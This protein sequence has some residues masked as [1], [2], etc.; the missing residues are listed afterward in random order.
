ML[1]LAALVAGCGSTYTGRDFIARADAICASATRRLRS[2][3]PP[4]LSQSQAP[5]SG[6]L[7]AYLAMVVSVVQSQSSQL[8]ALPRPAQ[9]AGGRAALARWRAAV[10]QVADDYRQLE[11]AG[12]RGDAQGA[13]SAEAALRA[14]PAGSLAA[15]DGLTSCAA[16][17]ATIT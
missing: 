7:A 11:A 5:Q 13:A 9:N 2:I 6:A 8:H 17:G 12:R 4:S 1:A 3:P 10:K 15:A 14:S 16:P